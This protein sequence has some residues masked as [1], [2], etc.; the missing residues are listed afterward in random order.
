MN[1]LAA[2][3]HGFYFCDFESKLFQALILDIVKKQGEMPSLKGKKKNQVQSWL[4]N[5]IA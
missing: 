2:L 3:C 5:Q 1:G 4:K